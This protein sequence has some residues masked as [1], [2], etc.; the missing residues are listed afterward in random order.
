MQSDLF[1][2]ILARVCGLASFAALSIALLT[3][4]ALRTAVLDWL[5]NNR[6]L[7]SVHEFSAV[8]WIP[9]GIL[10]V[11]ALV[12]DRTARI[13]LTDLV[14]PFQV[15][16]PG[17]PQATLAIGLGTVTLELLVA[18]A[19]T[20]WLK[21][22]MPLAI[23]QWIHRL[24]YVA[25][26]LLFLH[27]VLSGSDFSDPVVSALTWSVAFCLAVISAARVLWGRLPA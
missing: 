20:G 18:V 4:A 2:W 23:W 3:G 13:S 1:F 5:A 12:L 10:H 22:R 8:L 27:A 26:G 24:S 7:R 21:R 16:Y 17:A 6:A 15:Q 25:Y 19:V 11:A 9:L 14:L